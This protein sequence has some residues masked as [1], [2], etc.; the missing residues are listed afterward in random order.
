MDAMAETAEFKTLLTPS[1]SA[2]MDVEG[3]RLDHPKPQMRQSSYSPL[4]NSVINEQLAKFHSQTLSDKMM[5]TKLL[6]YKLTKQS[7]ISNMLV[8]KPV[9]SNNNCNKNIKGAKKQK[10][11]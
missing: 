5:P 6:N 4:R 7:D 9:A 10:L 2:A 11:I 3:K 8:I 1:A